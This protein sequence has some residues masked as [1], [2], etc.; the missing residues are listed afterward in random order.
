MQKIGHLLLFS[1]SDCRILIDF[2]FLGYFY[3]SITQLDVAI[4]HTKSHQPID[5]TKSLLEQ[6]IDS[7]QSLLELARKCKDITTILLYDFFPALI[8]F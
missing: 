2:R 1:V 8:Q 6:P 5:S 3:Q 7:T 4:C